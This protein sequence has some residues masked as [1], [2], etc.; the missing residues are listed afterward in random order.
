MGYRWHDRCWGADFA[1]RR[2]NCHRGYGA[3]AHRALSLICC[4]VRSFPAC[5]AHVVAAKSRPR[6]RHFQYHNYLP[7]RARH[8][9]DIDTINDADFGSP[10]SMV[11]S[12]GPPWRKSVPGSAKVAR[13]KRDNQYPSLHVDTAVLDVESGSH[14]LVP[15]ASYDSIVKDFVGWPRNNRH[16]SCR[17]LRNGRVHVML[18]NLA[19]CHPFSSAFSSSLSPAWPVASEARACV[20]CL[21]GGISSARMPHAR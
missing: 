11:I 6:R 5:S 8:Q 13:E 21:L 7:T 3:G 19:L 16:H 9:H 4:H 20:S 15:V 2:R 12:R 18:L 10:D 14:E 17:M 1:P